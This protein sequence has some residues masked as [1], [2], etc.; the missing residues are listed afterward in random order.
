M[1]AVE[2]ALLILHAAGNVHAKTLTDH[3]NQ[4]RGLREEAQ[5]NV[6]FLIE[7]F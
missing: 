4:I 3:I 2:R 6:K 7:V 1:N 5:D